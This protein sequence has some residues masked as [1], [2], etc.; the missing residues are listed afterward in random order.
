MHKAHAHGA[1]CGREWER[2]SGYR[3]AALFVVHW[4]DVVAIRPSHHQHGEGHG[5][6]RQRRLC[7]QWRRAATAVTARPHLLDERGA[8][9][10]VRPQASTLDLDLALAVALALALARGPAGIRATATASTRASAS[11]ARS[12]AHE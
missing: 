1:V 11:A 3:A 8:V 6:Q 4:V 10:S 2:G 7:Q 5:R 9:V 12:E